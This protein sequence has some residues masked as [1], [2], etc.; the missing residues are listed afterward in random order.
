M[1]GSLAHYDGWR[2]FDHIGEPVPAMVR[3]VRLWL[4]DGRDVRIF[5]ARAFP[6]AGVSE[7]DVRV[8]IDRWCL[9][10]LGR[11]LPITYIK[12]MNMEVLYDDRCRQVEL[13]T[14][15]IVGD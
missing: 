15:R 9:L 11:V 2:G 1:D 5:T 14:G 3:R 13:N 4:A 12:D 10:H 8:P 7:A 6:R